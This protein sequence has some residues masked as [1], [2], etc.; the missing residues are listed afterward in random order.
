MDNLLDFIKVSPNAVAL[1]NKKRLLLVAS[2]KIYAIFGLPTLIANRKK[3][4]LEIRFQEEDSLQTKLSNTI[5]KIKTSS[6]ASYF[7]WQFNDKIYDV[8]VNYFT[9]KGEKMY[10]LIFKDVSYK[11]KTS[12]PYALSRQFLETIINDLPVG[13][14]VIDEL[15][16]IFVANETQ[17]EFFSRMHKNAPKDHSEVVGFKV[18]DVFP[19]CKDVSWEKIIAS[20]LEAE[21]TTPLQFIDTYPDSVFQYTVAPFINEESHSQS[22]II[23]AEDVTEKTALE[24]ELKIASEQTTKLKALEE[25]NVSLRHKIYNVITPIS[26]NAELIKHSLPEEGMEDI[27]EMSESIVSEVRRLHSFIEQ[28]SKM[29]E[30]KS[31]N[32]LDSEDELMLNIEE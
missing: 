25:I 16:N 23:I 18:C 22:A 10:Q 30:V 31:V 7:S 13:V 28:L 6:T 20:V 1:V 14:T 26:M 9:W 3:V 11:F 19:D 12:S 15:Q 4:E 5:K 32:Y 21:N 17:M 27:Q 29:S 2:K 24:S 8:S